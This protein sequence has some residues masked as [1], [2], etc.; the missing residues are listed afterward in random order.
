MRWSFIHWWRNERELLEPEHQHSDGPPHFVRVQTS[1]RSQI[2]VLKT[3]LIYGTYADL[4]S[5]QDLGEFIELEVNQE[6]LASRLFSSGPSALDTQLLPFI[7]DLLGFHIRPERNEQTWIWFH[8]WSGNPEFR[9]NGF[10][11]VTSDYLCTCATS[12]I[13]C[14]GSSW[15]P[16][17][18]EARSAVSSRTGLG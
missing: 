15:I 10:K 7:V 6:H 18:P 13:Y 17:Q 4:W 16:Q 14:S 12:Y 8:A 3:H 5:L 1:V 9:A 2:F 11:T